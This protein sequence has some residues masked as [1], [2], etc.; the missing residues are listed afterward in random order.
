MPAPAHDKMRGFSKGLGKT[1]LGFQD[2]VEHFRLLGLLLWALLFMLS[3]LPEVHSS[4]ATFLS[5]S[6]VFI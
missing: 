6:K 2:R 4:R 5:V 1:S 3:L